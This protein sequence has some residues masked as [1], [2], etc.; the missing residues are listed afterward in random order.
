MREKENKPQS[1]HDFKIYFESKNLK[2]FSSGKKTEKEKAC[3]A[4]VL[5]LVYAIFFK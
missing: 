5:V 2:I 1:V 3:F 4:N